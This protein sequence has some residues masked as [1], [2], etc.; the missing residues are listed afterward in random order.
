MRQLKKLELFDDQGLSQQQFHKLC[1]LISQS[2]EQADQ[3]RYI[4]ERSLKVT[5]E[6]MRGLIHSQQKNYQDRQE[7]IFNALPDLLFLLDENGCF[8]EILAEHYPYLMSEK[9]RI[10]VGNTLHQTFPQKTADYFLNEIRAAIET[11]QLKK[12]EYTF[13]DGNK[14]I[15]FEIR[16]VVTQQIENGKRT[17]L[18]L[19]RD[20]TDSKKAYEQAQLLSTVMAV[21][22]EG[23]VIVNKHKKVLYANEA[24]KKITRMSVEQLINEGEGFL[25]HEKDLELCADI[26]RIAH[27]QEHLQREILIHSD[28]SEPVTAWLNLTTI[29]DQ[30]Q[31][32]EYFVGVLSDMSEIKQYHEQLK[33]VASHDALTQLPNRLMFVERFEQSLSRAKRLE[34]NGALLFLDL[35]NF[36][37]INDTLGHS[38]GDELLLEVAQRLQSL[39]RKEDTVARFGG[40]EFVMLLEDVG[41]SINTFSF[42]DKLLDVFQTKVHIQGYD[43][44]ISTSVGVTIYPEQ[45]EE[46][47]QLLKQADAAM[48]QAK[49]EGKNRAFLFSDDLLD[50]TVA[51]FTLGIELRQA[52][53]NG[54]FYLEYQPQIDIK[55]QKI[56]GAEALIRWLHPQKGLI[57]PSQFIPAAEATGFI[58]KIGLWVFE[59]VCL[60]LVSWRQA[61]IPFGKIS[62]NL[63]QRQLIDGDLFQHLVE[64]LERTGAM[65]YIQDLVCEITESA[66]FDDAEN[67]YQ[68]LFMMS[69]LGMKL[70]IDDFGTGHSSLLNL[71][72][73][74]LSYLKID[75]SFV[76]D[77]G[78]DSNDEAI[79]E[80]TLVL[81]KNF[82]LTV[83]AEGV[84]TEQQ[85][86]FLQSLDC[87]YVQGFYFS[88]PVKAD[89]IESLLCT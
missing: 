27:E 2:Y 14:L 87:A 1:N 36:K 45:G 38:A 72:R 42:I 79:I 67:A 51:G 24:M 69:G 88:K 40:D 48:Y 28:D 57:S 43:L 65:Q 53:E 49:K 73:F 66:I 68:N 17:V 84:E 22:Q 46:T 83:I 64:C 78:T 76:N 50:N 62:F 56:V 58:D 89:E 63:S 20:V 55:T 54:E 29:R 39:C 37:S 15:D 44:D 74:P 3:D 75:R 70:S 8:L 23:V 85:L 59:Q 7:A 80:A 9:S 81:A 31:N 86:Q 26:C 10:L 41:N 19:A 52:L 18:F 34:V 11:Q 13:K 33:H 32:L 77:V 61:N 35:D 5:S 30:N 21:A 4:L 47:E 82:G 25:R 16:I 71:K 60:Q 12:L 6:E